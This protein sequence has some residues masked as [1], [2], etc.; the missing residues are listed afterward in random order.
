MI[1]KMALAAVA[2]LAITGCAKNDVL[3]PK[4]YDNLIVYGNI[5]TARV[6][7]SKGKDSSERY[8]MA[9]A[10]AVKDGKFVCVG[11][12]AEVD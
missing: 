7:E 3:Q 8:V 10:M 1:R 4:E 12:K 11:T 2:A 6:D 5:Y 9:E